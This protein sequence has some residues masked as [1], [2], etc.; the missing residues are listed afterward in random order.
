MIT[1]FY[2]ENQ[3][4]KL[5]DNAIEKDLFK[6]KID[7]LE[8][9]YKTINKELENKSLYFAKLYEDRT[10][11]LLQEKE[12]IMLMNKYKDDSSKLEDR[13][14]IIK[15]EII[16][17]NAKK[18]Q[19]KNKKTIF[20]KY[21]KIDVLGTDIINDFVDKVLIGYYDEKTNSR[22]IKVIWNFQI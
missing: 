7:N 17:T 11:G 4:N 10:S 16:S 20:K 6:E 22:D 14:K 13:L 5:N 19:L 21:R 12:F 8:K 3:L 15:K 18:N 2:D 9:E 1:K